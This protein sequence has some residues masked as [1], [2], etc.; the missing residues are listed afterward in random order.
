VVA[1]RWPP[2][3]DGM[4]TFQPVDRLATAVSVLLAG[5]V[6][7]TGLALFPEHFWDSFLDIADDDS[8]TAMLPTL[9][10]GLGLIAAV[11]AF[12]LG[13]FVVFLVWMHRAAKNARVLLPS[14]P[15]QFT[16]G[17]CVGWWFVPFMNLVRPYQ[18]MVEIYQASAAAAEQEASSP[19]S[20]T[21]ARAVPSFVSVW[22]GAWVL[23]NLFDRISMRAEHTGVELAAWIANAVAAVLCVLVVRSVSQLQTAAAARQAV[24][25]RSATAH[26][27]GAASTGY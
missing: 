23:S 1:P 16:P 15:Y 4:S 20:P 7:L 18:A 8:L 25:L 26:A 3:N 6:G 14:A 21:L 13:T 17:W 11:V 22:W 2:Y 27:V 9:L 10:G 12:V 19:Y 5:Q 24:T